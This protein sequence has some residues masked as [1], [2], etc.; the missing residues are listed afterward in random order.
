MR[1]RLRANGNVKT[2]IK[3]SMILIL[4]FMIPALILIWRMMAF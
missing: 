2:A 4:F 3:I 1:E